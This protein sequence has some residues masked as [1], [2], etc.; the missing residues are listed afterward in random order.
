VENQDLL[1]RRRRLF[2]DSFE[3]RK[4]ETERRRRKAQNSSGT[5][6]QS[7]AGAGEG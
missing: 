1:F 4:K 7:K 6:L 5:D 2:L 3:A